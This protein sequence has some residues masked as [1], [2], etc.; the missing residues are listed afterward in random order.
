[1]GSGDSDKSATSFFIDLD[2]TLWDKVIDA[3]A[4]LTYIANMKGS[5]DVLNKVWRAPERSVNVI[6]RRISQSEIPNTSLRQVWNIEFRTNY[7][8]NMSTMITFKQKI[9]FIKVS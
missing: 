2:S 3:I 5:S 6:C 1:M 8:F 4:V 9:I 7:S